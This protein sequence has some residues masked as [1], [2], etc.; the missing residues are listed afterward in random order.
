MG[1]HIPG[2]RNQ[3]DFALGYGWTSGL[4]CQY[5]RLALSVRKVDSDAKDEDEDVVYWV[6]EPE[7]ADW[8]AWAETVDRVATRGPRLEAVDAGM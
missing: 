1:L 7:A 2:E 6:F 5:R 3:W 4:P 8:L